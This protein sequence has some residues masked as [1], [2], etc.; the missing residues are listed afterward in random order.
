L[1]FVSVPL[2]P[3]PVG[4]LCP[5]SS[6]LLYCVLSALQ[7]ACEWVTILPRIISNGYCKSNV[8]QARPLLLFVQEQ[9]CCWLGSH[10]FVLGTQHAWFPSGLV[11]THL[12]CD[13]SGSKAKPAIAKFSCS[14]A[15][16][17]N[18]VSQQCSNKVMGSAGAQAD[19]GRQAGGSTPDV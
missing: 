10:L 2:G 3:Y 17:G 7:I 19:K 13:A 15:I 9:G 14:Q 4:L 5:G 1:V 11:P 12:S 8:R 18:E 6:K 16:P